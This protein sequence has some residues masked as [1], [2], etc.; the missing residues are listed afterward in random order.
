MSAVFYI[1]VERIGTG[2]R[3]PFMV[4]RQPTEQAAREY[5]K[6]AIERSSTPGDL[7]VVHVVERAAQRSRRSASRARRSR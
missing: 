7:R 2:E 4:V 1:T 6:A 3:S 5:A